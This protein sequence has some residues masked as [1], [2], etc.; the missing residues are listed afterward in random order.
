MDCLRWRLDFVAVDDEGEAEGEEDVTEDVV[1]ED[2]TAAVG[3]GIL[4]V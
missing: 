4:L 1:E 3:E 2:G